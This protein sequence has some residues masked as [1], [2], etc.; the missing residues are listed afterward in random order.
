VTRSPNFKKLVDRIGLGKAAQRLHV[1]AT[2]AGRWLKRGVPASR[3]SDVTKAWRRSEAGRLASKRAQAKRK[4]RGE[5]AK[6]KLVIKGY[7]ER[8]RERTRTY[9]NRIDELRE[10]Y[11]LTPTRSLRKLAKQYG[12][13]MRTVYSNY[14]SPGFKSE[15]A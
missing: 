6:L 11:V 9:W 4:P 3:V 5:V 8:E 12:M 13:P 2:T 10:K 14:Y 7:E 1:S 15:A